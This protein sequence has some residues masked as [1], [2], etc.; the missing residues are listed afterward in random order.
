MSINKY[1]RLISDKPYEFDCNIDGL[2][3]CVCLIRPSETINITTDYKIGDVCIYSFDDS[4]NKSLSIVEI[5]KLFNN[6]PDIAE[7]KFIKVIVDDTG[8]DYFTYLYNIGKTM[9]ASLKYLKNLT[10]RNK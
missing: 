1:V 8:N 9:N 7:I 2:Q 3:K 10:P 5:V 6:Y 4:K